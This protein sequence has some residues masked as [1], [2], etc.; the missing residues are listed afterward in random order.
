[1]LMEHDIVYA[2]L[3]TIQICQLIVYPEAIVMTSTLRM[4]NFGV[5]SDK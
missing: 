5:F 2:N 1:M 4:N 3:L